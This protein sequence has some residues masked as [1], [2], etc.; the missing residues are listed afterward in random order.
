MDNSTLVTFFLPGNET[1]KYQFRF[2]LE[3][4][5]FLSI[6]YTLTTLFTVAGNILVILVFVRGRHSRTDLRPYLINLAVADLI[7]AVFCMPFTFG[8]AVFRSWIFTEPLCPIVIFMQTLSVAASVFINVAIGIDRFLVV[9][10]PLMSKGSKSRTKFVIATIWVFSL[11]VSLVVVPV[12]RVQKVGINNVACNE[13]WPDITHKQVYTMAIFL[14]TY[15]IPLIILTIS[16]SVVGFLLW[17]RTS[18][19]NRDHVRDL[20]QLKSKIK[21]RDISTFKTNSIF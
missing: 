21:V 14:L 9:T 11:A 17:K 1:T 15:A 6:L 10:F 2:S 20:L 19:G 12:A 13:F 4:L 8:D 5:I 7:M 3:W 18:P 16:Y